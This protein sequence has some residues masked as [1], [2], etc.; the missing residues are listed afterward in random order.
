M[1]ADALHAWVIH[2]YWSGDTS[3]RVVFFTRERGLVHGLFKGG[4]TPKKQALLQAFIPLWLTL[5]LRGESCFVR[6][7]ESLDAPLQLTGQSLFASLYVNELIFHALKPFD[8]NASLYDAYENTLKTLQTAIDKP[9]IE[10]ILRRFEWVL[11][12]CCGYHMSLTHEAHTGAPIL[13]NHDY[14]LI[15]GEGFVMV[16]EG[17][18]GAHILALEV[19]QLDDIAVLKN[20]K[21]ILRSAID[22][23]LDGKT[24]K[25]RLLYSHST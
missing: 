17:I 7:L 14:R 6:H 23:A 24:I 4:R 12:R 11:L 19:G 15:P 8:L 1:I 2:K 25:T 22:H 10:A 16:D 18:P 21:R 13:D 3:A 20:V 9:V 5:N